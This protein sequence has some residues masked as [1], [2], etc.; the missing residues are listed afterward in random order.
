MRGANVS[1]NKQYLDKKEEIRL[2]LRVDGYH[3]PLSFDDDIFLLDYWDFEQGLFYLVGISEIPEFYAENLDGSIHVIKTLERETYSEAEDQHI[4]EAFMRKLSRLQKIWNS[5]GHPQ[6]NPSSY[7]IEWALSKKI[8]IPWL[9][10]AIDKGFY[11][12]KE[13]VDNHNLDKSLNKRTENNYLRLIMALANGIKGFNPQKPYEAAQL[14]INETE[15][16]ISKET[17]ANY[18]SKAN[19]LESKNRD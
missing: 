1:E 4:T 2:A 14:I 12:S 10:Y 7:Y 5:G 19:E 8:D 3:F 17:L 13:I 6:S 15:I 9:Q 16:N 18:L 11:K